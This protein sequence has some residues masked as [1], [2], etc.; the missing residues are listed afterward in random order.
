MNISG[1][2]PEG[3]KRDLYSYFFE[4]YDQLP[5]II[6]VIFEV[7]RS[8]GAYEK[9]TN[10]IRGGLLRE[11]T[12]GSAILASNLLEGWTV[13]AK[14]RTFADSKEITVE[15]SQDFP[16]EKIANLLQQVALGW[17]ESVVA[18]KE[19]SAAEIFNY[20]GYTAGYTCFN[21]SIPG[22]VDDPSGNLCYDEKPF[23]NVTGNKR[24]NKNGSEYF[25]G[26]VSTSLTAENLQTA[27]TLMT[28][29]NAYDEKD[30]KIKI[31]PNILLIPPNLHFT[32]KAILESEKVTGTANNDINVVQNLV[33]PVEWSYLTDTDAWFLGVAKKGIVWYDRLDPVIE[34]YQDEKTKNYFVTIMAR[35]GLAVENWRYW[36]GFNFST[37]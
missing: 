14:N 12:E 15:M 10:A 18:T 8:V 30:Q 19:T 11:K 2:F 13:Y 26:I 23:F 6:P 22:V 27:Y 29:T 4:A 17:G 1:H 9:N 21:G 5:S 3:L 16:P 7:R 28:V 35:W 32:A 34:F 33:S 31:I 37:S 25:N 24:T 20:G 36:S